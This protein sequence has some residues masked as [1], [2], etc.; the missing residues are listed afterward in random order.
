MFRSV[1]L[2]SSM[3]QITKGVHFDTIAREW[4]FKWSADADKASLQAAQQKLTEVLAK[5]KAVKGVKRVQRVVCG[6]FFVYL[7]SLSYHA[8]FASF[9]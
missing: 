4:R 1:R 6:M 7:I 8:C 2:F 5:V 9:V 3:P